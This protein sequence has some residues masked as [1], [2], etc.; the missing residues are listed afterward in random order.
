MSALVIAG[1]TSGQISVTVPTVAGSNTITL[2]ASTGNALLDSTTGVCRAWVNFDGTAGTV[3]AAFN[4]GSITKNGTG[5]YTANFTNAIS[6]VNYALIA[7][8]TG[9]TGA[10]SFIVTGVSGTQAKTTTTAQMLSRNLSNTATDL[11]NLSLAVFR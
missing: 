2:P 7:S 8:T 5:D 4:V 11:N 6:D 10:G 3:K 9:S 1:D